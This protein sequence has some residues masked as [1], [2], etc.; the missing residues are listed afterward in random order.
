MKPVKIEI[1]ENKEFGLNVTVLG[2]GECGEKEIRKYPFY[3]DREMHGVFKTL[4]FCSTND[5]SNEV[6]S[7]I[8]SIFK[9]T[10]LLFIVAD[11]NDENELLYAEKHAKLFKKASYKNIVI[12]IDLSD[13]V[14][15]IPADFFDVIIS[16]DENAEAYKPIE[17]IISGMH[18]G[19]C[20]IDYADI[21]SILKTTSIMKFTYKSIQ[22]IGEKDKLI[23]YLNQHIKDNRIKGKSQNTM[24]TFYMSQDCGLEDI[25]EIL[26]KSTFYENEGTILW[27][28]KLNNDEDEKRCIVSMLYGVNDAIKS[29]NQHYKNKGWIL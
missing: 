11:S 5:Y 7:Q 10:E 21:Y 6:S 4:T 27:Q 15:K 17:M 25:E 12:L 20:G 26:I 1:S 16:V 23:D 29:E 2:I 22:S 9:E 3:I 18:W 8:K 14:D 28:S 24:F 19:L 13:N